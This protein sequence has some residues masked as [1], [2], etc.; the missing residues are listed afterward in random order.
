VNN[1]STAI[2]LITLALKD[3]GVIGEGQIPSSETVNDALTTLTDMLEVW[4]IDG[5]TPFA[6]VV[7]SLPV[8]GA[9]SYSITTPFDLEFVT[10]SS[11]NVNKYPLE[12]VTLEEF[13]N[14]TNNSTGGIPS[15]Y[16]Y[17]V[18]ATSGTL[19]VYPNPSSGYLLYGATT[20]L[21]NALALTTTV[22]VP[23]AYNQAIR[24]NLAVLLGTTFGVAIRQDTI[25]LAEQTL[26]II[27]R[28][29]NKQKKLASL[30]RA[31]FNILSGTRG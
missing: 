12:E 21:A 20:T 6:E 23:K 18:G 14:L 4:Q 10:Y 17:S 11:D 26:K 27:R 28:A 25:M 31:S 1:M 24:F 19:K 13:T 7:T 3:A 2:E 30:G 5:V 8:T 16:T 15:K 29:N 22:S 9:S